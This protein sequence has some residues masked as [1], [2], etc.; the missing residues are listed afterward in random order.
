MIFRRKKQA[1]T[2]GGEQAVMRSRA[3]VEESD[4][5]LARRFHPED[6]PDTIDLQQPAG[7]PQEPDT[8]ATQKKVSDKG[9]VG[10]V[11]MDAETGKFDLQPGPDGISVRLGGQ[12]VTAPTELRHGDRIRIGDSELIFSAENSDP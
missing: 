2:T 6:E 9:R 11:T 5:P 4:N 12:A 7:F 8:A 3:N 10:V 1:A